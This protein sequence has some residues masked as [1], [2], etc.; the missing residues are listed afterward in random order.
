[1][2]TNKQPL[3]RRCALA[4]LIY[5]G[6]GF[7]PAFGQRYLEEVIPYRNEATIRTAAGF[8]EVGFT[9]KEY[10]GATGAERT[11][12][13]YYRDSVYATQGGYHGYPLHG[14]YIER[15]A[16]KGLKVLGSYNYGLRHG[17]WHQWDENGVLRNVSH[18]KEGLETGRFAIYDTTGRLKQR[19]YLRHGKFNGI[20]SIYQQGDSTTSRDRMRYRRGKLVEPDGGNWLL[21]AR[22]WVRGLFW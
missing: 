22:D 9:R 18:W 8:I 10:I 16:D 5:A 14:R 20:V 7:W 17:K 2:N 15:Y 6:M 4:C 3:I 11:Y 13:S 21:Q 1:M 19:G 12:Y